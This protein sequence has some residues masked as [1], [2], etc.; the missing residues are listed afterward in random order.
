MGIN[1]MNA[2]DQAITRLKRNREHF[3][4]EELKRRYPKGYK[5]LV[6]EINTHSQWV[7][8]HFACLGFLVL[9]EDYEAFSKKLSSEWDAYVTKA[10]QLG[11][12]RRL[13]Y[14]LINRMDTDW[15]LMECCRLHLQIEKAAYLDYWLSHCTKLDGA[16][17]NDIIDMWYDAEANAWY[18]AGSF[19]CSLPPTRELYEQQWENDMGELNSDIKEKETEKVEEKA[20]V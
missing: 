10:N 18:N 19:Q 3:T 1:H 20:V 6:G 4:L 15:Y 17:Y 11:W 14:I 12:G 7:L 8:K 2:L 9:K 13:S 5:K 16:Y